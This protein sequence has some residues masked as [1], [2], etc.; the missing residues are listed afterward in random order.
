MSL[1]IG[2]IAAGMIL[3]LIAGAAI[4]Q[5]APNGDAERGK[6]LFESVGCFQCH[7]FVGQGGG[8]GPAIA[9]P[10]AFPPF[11]LQLR[12]PR[13]VMIPYSEDVLSDQAAADIHAYLASLPPPP[14]PASIPLLQSMP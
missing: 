6:E 8:A 5:D 7:G 9:P 14:D 11:E 2:R 4:A 10:M 1:R 12:T 3:S 13:A